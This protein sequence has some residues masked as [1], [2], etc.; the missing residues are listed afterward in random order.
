MVEGGRGKFGGRTSF[1]SAFCSAP[2]SLS[3]SLR[4]FNGP[5]RVDASYY[6]NLLSVATSCYNFNHAILSRLH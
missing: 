2:Y 5:S 3:H 1:T 4:Q 6:L